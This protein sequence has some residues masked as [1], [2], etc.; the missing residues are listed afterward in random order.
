MS[1]GEEALNEYRRRKEKP[2]SDWDETERAK[3]GR[4][5]LRREEWEGKRAG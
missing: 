2:G 3:R 1:D 4:P 5:V